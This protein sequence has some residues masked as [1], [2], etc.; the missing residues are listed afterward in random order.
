MRHGE[1][2]DVIPEINTYAGIFNGWKS[3]DTG[4]LIDISI[5]VLEDATYQAEWLDATL[6][7]QNGVNIAG[8]NVEDINLEALI[9]LV[10][11]VDVL[12]EEV[13]ADE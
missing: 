1:Q 3:V 10:E 8:I 13:N 2:L 5:P 12:R 9:S 7:L 6:L 11:A 4:K